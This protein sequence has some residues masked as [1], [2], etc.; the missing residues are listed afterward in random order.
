LVPREFTLFG[1]KV[2]N[3]RNGSASELL[4][5]ISTPIEQRGTPTGF[6]PV[7]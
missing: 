3:Q 6:E 4:H 7:L 1:W 2:W 5:T